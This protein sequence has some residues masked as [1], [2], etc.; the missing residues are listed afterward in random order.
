M[1]CVCDSCAFVPPLQLRFSCLGASPLTSAHLSSPQLSSAQPR[2]GAAGFQSSPALHR[3]AEQSAPEQLALFSTLFGVGAD[4]LFM[5]PLLP[6]ELL[7]GF[8]GPKHRAQLVERLSALAF[9]QPAKDDHLEFGGSSKLPPTSRR[10]NEPFDAADGVEQLR[11]WAQSASRGDADAL[12]SIG[13]S[14]PPASIT[15]STSSRMVARHRERT[16]AVQGCGGAAAPPA[17]DRG[18]CGSPAPG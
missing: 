5:T 3:D 17:P 18:W 6:Q 10:A 14:L 4:Q 2:R 16:E 11:R 7:Q 15:T 12:T 8:A 1:G 13:S 9:L